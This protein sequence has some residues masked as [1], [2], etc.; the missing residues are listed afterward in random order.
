MTGAV[1]YQ[2]TQVGY[3]MFLT[4]AGLAAL[5][6]ARVQSLTVFGAMC[7]IMTAV[8]ALVGTLTTSIDD[9]SV[10]VHFGP[11]SLIRERFLLTD[12]KS[13]RA[14]RSSPVHGWGVHYIAHGRLWNVWGLDAVELQLASGSRFRIGTDEPQALLNALRRSGVSAAPDW[15]SR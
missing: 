12:I 13:A 8:A 1:T 6:A 9:E 3:W 2:H 11:V 4:T 14:V 10:R 15:G 5:I 7:L